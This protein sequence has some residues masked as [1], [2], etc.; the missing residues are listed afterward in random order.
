MPAT[1]QNAQAWSGVLTLYENDAFQRFT[2]WSQHLFLFN[3]ETG[4]CQATVLK[5]KQAV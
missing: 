1:S 2:Y 5:V 3:A 4:E